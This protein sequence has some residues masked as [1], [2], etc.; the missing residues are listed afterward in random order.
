MQEA[1]DRKPCPYCGEGIRAEALKCRWCGEMLGDGGGP[2]ERPGAASPPPAT[3]ERTLF[4]GS[5]SQ[6]INIKAFMIGGA[7][8]AGALVLATIGAFEN[9]QWMVW[10]GLAGVAAAGA[11]V[12]RAYVGVRYV[13]YQITSRRIQVERGWLSR[14]VDQIDFVRVRDVDL[15]QGPLDR[16]FG[17]GDITVYSRDPT[18]PTFT[19]RGLATPRDVY[20]V[21][22][23]EAL[24]TIRRRGYVEV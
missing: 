17:I 6:W 23:R 5:G 16:L 10:V 9:R 8:L 1:T 13:R 15:R 24:T 11:Y 22:Q 3:E 7:V 4:E 14:H 18:T 20:E 2:S 12:V 19:L 21:I